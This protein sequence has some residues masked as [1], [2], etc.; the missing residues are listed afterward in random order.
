MARNLLNK[1]YNAKLI[2]EN[3]EK[4]PFLEKFYNNRQAHAFKTQI[5]FLLDRYQQYLELAQMDLFN[6]VIIID[7]FSLLHLLILKL[8]IG[9]E[10]YTLFQF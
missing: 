5:F 10:D 3:D 1:Q 6:S 7:Y 8:Q 2:L 4:N 9:I